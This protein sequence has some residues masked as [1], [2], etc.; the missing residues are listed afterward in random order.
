[1]LWKIPPEIPPQPIHGY[2][3]HIFTPESTRNEVA[4]LEILKIRYPHGIMV[5][6]D[7]FDWQFGWQTVWLKFWQRNIHVSVFVKI[8]KILSHKVGNTITMDVVVFWSTEINFWPIPTHE[9]SIS[10][11]DTTLVHFQGSQVTSDVKN[12]VWVKSLVNRDRE[13]TH[14]SELSQ[15]SPGAKMTIKTTPRG[16]NID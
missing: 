6:I 13:W 8:R 7:V 5:W 14:I 3:H 9:G 2:W 1:M 16:R 12:P 11:S 15:G 10:V 4:R